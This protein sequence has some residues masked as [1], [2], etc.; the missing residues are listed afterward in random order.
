MVHYRRAKT[1]GAC[2][3]LTLALR[4]RSSDMLVRHRAQ[5]GDALRLVRQQKPYSLPAIVLL[6]DHLHMLM[7]LPD[8]DADFSA[9]VR[10][11]KSSFVNALRAQDVQGVRLN[12]KGEADVW[13]RRFWEHLI[14][15]QRDFAAH[16][17][18]IH[19]NPL[20][21]GLVE[22]LGDWPFSSFHR[23]VRCGLLPADWAGGGEQA[24]AL[25]GE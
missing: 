15:D 5:L 10:L 1:P 16:V 3:F 20:K 4:D 11:L 8:G 6:P 25:A 12:A 14:R 13:Q 7:Q 24:V 22:R 17:D 9:R 23:Y 19:I 21:H 2:Y 18:Y